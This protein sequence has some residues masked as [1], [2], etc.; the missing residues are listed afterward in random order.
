M[1]LFQKFQSFHMFQGFKI[2]GRLYLAIRLD[3]NGL[4]DCNGWNE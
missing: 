3:F 1:N 4:N 2:S